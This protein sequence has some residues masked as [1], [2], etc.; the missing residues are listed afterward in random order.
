MLLGRE[1]AFE[2]TVL[3]EK[4][5]EKRGYSLPTP[6]P[7]LFEACFLLAFMQTFSGD[8]GGKPNDVLFIVAPEL[9]G[10]VS[11]QMTGVAK[12]IFDH[13]KRYGNAAVRAQ[14]LGALF[15]HVR[16]A[17]TLPP[18][19]PIYGWA[20]FGFDPQAGPEWFREALL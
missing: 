15:R 12:G 2:Q 13:C 1:P 16:V 4:F 6:D 19:A 7:V 8:D 20:T 17:R 11:E 5:P 10:W 9:N 18:L 3:Y 14:H